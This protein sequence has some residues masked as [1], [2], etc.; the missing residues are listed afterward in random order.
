M[1]IQRLRNL[2]TGKLHT[3]I[4]HIYTDLEAITG[5]PGLMTHML[6]G[7][8]KAVKPW[9]REHVTD[10]RFWDGKYDPTHAGEFLLP[11]PTDEDRKIMM[12]RFF[13]QPDPIF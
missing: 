4:S 8:L 11:I 13:Q 9:L 3:D 6:P 7:A 1:D 12:D 10:D 2:T 5:Q